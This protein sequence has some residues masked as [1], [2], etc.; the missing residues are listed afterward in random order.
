[1]TKPKTDHI[2]SQ[3]ASTPVQHQQGGL[4]TFARIFWALVGN[5]VV[6]FVALGI[7]QRH[8][9]LTSLDWAYWITVLLLIVVRYC[10]IK[11]LGG[12]TA[13]DEPATMAHWRK[14]AMF[15]LLIAAGIWL[16]AHG[17]ALLT[18]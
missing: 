14:Y 5:A 7:Y 6:F 9:G 18:K 10:D 15:L 17:L 13:K 12:L 3:P 4:G 8:T 16:L 1:M 2:S 11:Y